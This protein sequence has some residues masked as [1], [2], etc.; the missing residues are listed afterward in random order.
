MMDLKNSLSYEVGASHQM[1]PH[2]RYCFLLPSGVGAALVPDGLC[3]E[4]SGRRSRVVLQMGGGGLGSLDG[5]M[6]PWLG[7]S[8]S[9]WCMHGCRGSRLSPAFG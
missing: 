4:D 5:F 3:E 8:A 6:T 9:W 1:P 2:L 7:F